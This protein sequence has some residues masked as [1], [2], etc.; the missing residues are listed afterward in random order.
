M[1]SNFFSEERTTVKITL[2]QYTNHR[3]FEVHAY[4]ILYFRLRSCLGSLGES[5][6]N[7]Q[8]V[9]VQQAVDAIVY[10]NGDAT[11]TASALRT[12]AGQF[13]IS[14]RKRVLILLTDGE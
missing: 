7:K 11:F 8:H 13:S 4:Y 3:S 14:D 6:Y 1:L 10:D 2:G 12:A 9:F 5:L